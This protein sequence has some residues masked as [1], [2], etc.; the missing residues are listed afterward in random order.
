MDHS[1]FGKAPTRTRPRFTLAAL[2]IGVGVVLGPGLITAGVLIAISQTRGGVQFAA[3][4]EVTVTA[5][6]PRSFVIWH[7]TS[8]VFDG[9]VHS[10]PRGGAAGL[11]IVVTQQGDARQ[12]PVRASGGGTMTIGS[13]QRET[14]AAF[15]APSAGEYR[16]AVTGDA[17]G[18]VLFVAPD[19]LV[20][21]IVTILAT[22]CGGL[23]GVACLLTGIVLLVVSVVRRSRA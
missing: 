23:V 15:D 18:Q 17:P 8:G 21:F 20:G 6:Q 2:L 13:T 11:Q 22:S 19:F 12:I 16:I 1:P 9:R 14:L 3:P 7:E 5:D 4:G 10:S